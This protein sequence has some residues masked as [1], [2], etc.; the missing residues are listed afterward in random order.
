MSRT[1]CVLPIP[2]DDSLKLFPA[3]KD[4]N[5]KT[6]PLISVENPENL[7]NYDFHYNPRICILNNHLFENYEN[8]CGAEL[9]Y[10][11]SRC[12][13]EENKD[14]AHLAILGM[15]GDTMEKDINKTR[16]RII[17]EANVRIKKGL[18]IYPSTRPLDKALEYSARPFIPGITGDSKGTF[19]LLKEIGIERTGKN[20]K[21][22][23]D[24]DNDEMK[25][26]VTAIMLRLN[27]DEKT[28]KLI[29]NLY[30]IKFLNKIED[31]REVSAII[32]ACGRMDRTEIALMLC[33]GNN[34]ARKRAE[35]I[36]VKYRQNIILGLR[37]IE[38]NSKIQGKNSP[39]MGAL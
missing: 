11:V 39:T 3:S 12:I 34:S 29:G 27:S 32:N 10:L 15:I 14:L 38:E 30:L 21:S 18:L 16:N 9:S 17:N 6:A 33:L 8:L 37:Y 25:R 26:L 2:K 7:E 35:N 22:L 23:I 24:L 5:S 31:A 28:S 20:Y 4:D 1:S 36:Y 13:S 19:N